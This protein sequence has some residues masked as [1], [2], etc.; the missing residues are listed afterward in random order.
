MNADYSSSLCELNIINL[1]HYAYK[2]Y[3]ENVST[4]ELMQQ[5]TTEQQKEEIALVALLD[6]KD[7]LNINLRYHKTYKNTDKLPQLRIEILQALSSIKD[8]RALPS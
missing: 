8:R 5:A 4:I 2:R 7:D 3:I 1:T 6:V